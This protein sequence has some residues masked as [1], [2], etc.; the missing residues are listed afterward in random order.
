[1]VSPAQTVQLLQLQSRKVG[2]TAEQHK[3]SPSV[4]E[5]LHNPGRRCSPA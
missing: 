3:E 5:L 1:M 2:A 4:S